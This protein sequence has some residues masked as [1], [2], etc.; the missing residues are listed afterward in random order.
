MRGR[1]DER[2]G[3]TVPR[4]RGPGRTSWSGAPRTLAL[5]TLPLRVPLALLA[6]QA[7]LVGLV[8]L[9]LGATPAHAH[10]GLI[11][12]D[13]S[14]G[15]VLT[16]VPSQVVLTFSGD[17]LDLG[18]VVAVVGPDGTSWSSGDA[19]VQGPTVTQP[20]APDMP[21]GAYAVDWRSAA[22]DGHVVEGSFA[23][24]LDVPAAPSEP[25]PTGDPAPSGEPSPE[26]VASPDPS[27]DVIA[28]SDPADAPSAGSPQ[29][30]AGPL[31]GWTVAGLLLLALAVT[32]AVLVVRRRS[33]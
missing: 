5:R 27:G 9:V 32:A 33:R 12:S 21:A 13:P 30:S 29:P 14:D 2:R 20:L 28:P 4:T 23:F 6:L 15:S 3:S 8:G 31:V 26:P 7:V 18:T 19:V 24:T 11:G 16:S 22:G 25:T 1:A 17:Q 10:D